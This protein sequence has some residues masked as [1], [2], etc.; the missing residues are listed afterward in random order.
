MSYHYTLIRMA[1]VCTQTTQMLAKMEQ[2]GLSFISG[3]NVKCY[4]P[5]D[6]LKE[7]SP[8]NSLEGLM[9]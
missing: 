5:F 6:F 4:S 8:E 1:R 3:G 7:I 9:L 2:Q